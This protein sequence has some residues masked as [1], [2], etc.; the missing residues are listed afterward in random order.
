MGKCP[1]SNKS[2]A[3]PLWDTVKLTVPVMHWLI[4]RL[5]PLVVEK[6]LRMAEA[7]ACFASILTSRCLAWKAAV[8][9]AL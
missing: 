7:T 6:Q 4:G 9:S 3:I 8:F 2:L 1:K 5:R